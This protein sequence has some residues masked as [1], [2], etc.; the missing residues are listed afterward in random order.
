MGTPV[1]E[2]A[3]AA[4]RYVIISCDALAYIDDVGR[5]WSYTGNITIGMDFAKLN[6]ELGV[7]KEQT[8]GW[9]DVKPATHGTKVVD[10]PARFR[11]L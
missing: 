10:R 2:V 8:A 6:V 9:T 11:L 5:S 3:A 7:W 1:G 4:S